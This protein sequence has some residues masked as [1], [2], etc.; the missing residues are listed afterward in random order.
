MP[1]LCYRIRLQKQP[2][3]NGVI[4]KP[5]ALAVSLNVRHTKKARIPMEKRVKIRNFDVPT[6][7]HQEGQI[8]QRQN[9]LSMPPSW[10][11]SELEPAELSDLCDQFRKDVFA[12]AGKPDPRC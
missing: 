4:D 1:V 3:G 9:G 12:Q 6:H 8:G 5:D 11:L 7:V 2:H 10:K